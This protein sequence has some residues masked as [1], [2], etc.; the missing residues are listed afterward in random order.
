MNKLTDILEGIKSV[1]VDGLDSLKT[2]AHFLNYVMHPGLVIQALWNYTQAYAFW[3]CLLVCL[4]AAIAYGLG[5]KKFAKW[6]PGS[7]LIFSFI[8][9]IG[10]AF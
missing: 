10:G 3:V 4:L 2:I 5:F 8:K 6:I 1:G 9:A 7:V